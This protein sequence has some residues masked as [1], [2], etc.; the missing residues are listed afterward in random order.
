MEIPPVRRAL[1]PGLAL[2]CATLAAYFPAL[3]GGLIWNDSDYI[4]QPELRSL[5]GLKRIWFD[6][7][8]TQ[9]YYPVLHSAFWLEHRMWGD[10][11][12]GYHL[13]NVILHATGAC[14][15]IVLL[16]RLVG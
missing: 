15:F 5:H 3:R 14:L 9:Q 12:A 10:A 6:L 16:Q 1:W 4:T 7:G 2:W 11:P 8:A 13:I